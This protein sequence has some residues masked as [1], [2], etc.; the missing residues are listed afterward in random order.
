MASAISRHHNILR[1]TRNRRT[2]FFHELFLIRSDL[3]YRTGAAFYIWWDE[4][5]RVS[6]APGDGG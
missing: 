5:T 1:A 6:R 2:R 4:F 3:L